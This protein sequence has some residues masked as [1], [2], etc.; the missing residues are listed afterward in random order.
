MDFTRPRAG[1]VEDRWT[2]LAHGP[3]GWR[4]D[5]R[6]PSSIAPRILCS[7]SALGSISIHTQ[8]LSWSASMSWTSSSR[9]ARPSTPRRPPLPVGVVAR[10]DLPIRRRV[11]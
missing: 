5:G 3:D 8:P 2:S 10:D 1:Q 9:V 11:G 6:E 4:M 7:A